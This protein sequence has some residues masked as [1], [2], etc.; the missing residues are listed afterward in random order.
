MLLFLLVGMINIFSHIYWRIYI[1]ICIFFITGCTSPYHEHFFRE[2]PEFT[3]SAHTV[4][5]E[6][7]QSDGT[8]ESLPN[9]NSQTHLIAS[10]DAAKKRIWIEIYTWTDAAKL[11]EPILR[12]HKR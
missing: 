12:A 5:S 7:F 4:S 3:T 8:L 9:Q 6:I 2:H 10:L 11:V 1:F